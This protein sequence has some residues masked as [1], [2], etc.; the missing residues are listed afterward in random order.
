MNQQV[1]PN[2]L[3]AVFG[4]GFGGQ[5]NAPAE[6]EC[7]GW[8]DNVNEVPNFNL[9]EDPKNPPELDLNAPAD[10]QEMIID[11]IIQGPQPQE[12]FLE[13][14]DLLNQFN[15]EEED[16][17]G[18]QNDFFPVQEEVA[19]PVN[20]PPT[21]EVNIPIL[22]ELMVDVFPLE[23]QEDEF[24]NDDEIQRQIAEEA[25]QENPVGPQNLHVGY[26]L[27]NIESTMPMS[28]PV[29]SSSVYCY[30]YP[31][32]PW[33]KFFAPR[34]KDAIP[35]FLIPKDWANFFTMLL[36]S[37]KH[38]SRAKEL[39]QSKA[40]SLASM[41]GSMLAFPCQASALS[42]HFLL[43]VFGMIVNQWQKTLML[44]PWKHLPLMG[45]I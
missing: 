6:A 13:L 4:G 5:D 2:P 44:T 35:M 14:N 11:P 34:T 33:A 25:A 36:M 45:M 29:K 31:T 10:M 21:V 7:N 42:R 26:V 23:I 22:N 43:V 15:E 12:M 27:I 8:P 40:C 1:G 41:M 16:E 30:D 38:F 3:N 19:H 32:G 24:M 28:L 37:P 17:Q 20:N 9:N 39:M 18:H